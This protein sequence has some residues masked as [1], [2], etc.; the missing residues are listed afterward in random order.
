MTMPT[1]PA[2]VEASIS[3]DGLLL[4]ADE[5]LLALQRETGGD[6]GERLAIP[7]LA[8]VARLAARLGIVVSRPVAAAS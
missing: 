1:L 4:S 6:L 2:I 7:Q 3:A 8:A 5:P